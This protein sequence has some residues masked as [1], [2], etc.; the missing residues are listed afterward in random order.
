M[1]EKPVEVEPGTLKFVPDRFN[2]HFLSFKAVEAAPW[3]LDDVLDHFKTRK[4]CNDAVRKGLF[5][6]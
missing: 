2:T 1:C 4:M 6:V 5:Y 3:Q